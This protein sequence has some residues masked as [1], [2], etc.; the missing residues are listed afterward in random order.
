MQTQK[1]FTITDTLT[2]GTFKANTV[3]V[4][5]KDSINAT[6][7]TELVANTDYTINNYA[8]GTGLTVNFN[9]NSAYAGKIVVITYTAIAGEVTT[10]AP[11]TTTQV[12]TTELEKSL[13]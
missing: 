6:T 5:L 11:L 4:V 12:Q 9:Y 10:E 2:N 7:E 8:N 13:K 1:T 3:K